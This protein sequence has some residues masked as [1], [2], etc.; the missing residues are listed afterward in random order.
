M[1]LRTAIQVS[2]PG[3]GWDH[4][5]TFVRESERLGVDCCWVAEA[6]G[7]DATMAAR[8]ALSL[9]ALSGG[10]FVLGLGASG[11]QVVEGLDG[12]AFDRRCTACA[13]SLL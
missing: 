10:R 1:T 7:A 4:V 5:S 12:A 8:T 9:S 6:W 3:A 2:N 11:P 13:T